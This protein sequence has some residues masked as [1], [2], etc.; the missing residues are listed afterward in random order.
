M[1]TFIK[2]IIWLFLVLA[3]TAANAQ[4]SQKAAELEIEAYQYFLENNYQKASDIYLKAIQ[5]ELK[6]DNPGSIFIARCYQSLAEVKQEEGKY[7]EAIGYLFQAMDLMKTEA[8]TVLVDEFILQLASYYNA[9]EEN[10]LM[11]ETDPDSLQKTWVVFRIDSVLRISNDT[12]WVCINGG[13]N[14]NITEGSTGSAFSV[15]SGD[16]PDRG[17][18]ILGNGRLLETGLNHS[19][20]YVVLNNTEDADYQVRIGDMLEFPCMLPA[21]DETSVFTNLAKL[22]ILFNN[23]ENTPIFE[24]IE[25]LYNT[26]L[27]LEQ[28]IIRLMV[29]D[30]HKT[31]E[32][33]QEYVDDNPSWTAPMEGGKYDGMS[34]MYGL[35][36]TTVSD[37]E[38]F[39]NFVISYPGKY[40][41]KRWKIN[42]TYATWLINATPL[43]EFDERM[44]QKILKL[45]GNA[46]DEYI[47]ENDFYIQDS[48]LEKFNTFFN[49]ALNEHDYERAEKMVD[50]LIRITEIIENDVYK[51]IFLT[52]KGTIRINQGKWLESL[53]SFDDAIGI[54]PDNLNA[55]FFRGYAYGELEDYY[56]AVQDYKKITEINP[57]ISVGHGNMGWYMLL[58]GRIFGA[59]DA[60]RKAY[61][62]DSSAMSNAVNLGHAHLLLGDTASARPYYDRTLELL[63]TT[64][65]F[66][67]GPLADFDI[68][69]ENGWQT[70]LVSQAKNYVLERFNEDYKYYVLADS[71]S[72]VAI[73]NK[74]DA[75]YELAAE[76]MLKA[77]EYEKQSKNPRPY[78]LYWETSWIGY[79][80]QQME[81]YE[82]TEEYYKLCLHYAHDVMKSDDK[83]ANAYDLL[84]WLY[85]DWGK[86]SEAYA[87]T[88]KSEAYARKVEESGKSRRIYLL[89][90][91]N[92]NFEELSY[93]YADEDAQILAGL[94]GENPSQYYDSVSTEVITNE[95][96][97]LN[98]LEQAFKNVI[99]DSR[100][101][102]V[103]VFY[104]GGTGSL[105]T[106][107]F[108]LNIP[109]HDTTE[110]T[111][112]LKVN[113]IKTWL[114]SVQARNQFLMLDIF[115][116]TFIDEFV[117]NYAISRGAFSGSN[118]NLGILSLAGHRI[119]DDSLKHGA[120]THSVLDII[121]K[122]SAMPQAKDKN[123]SIK[124]INAHLF[125]EQK[126]NG[127]V[128]SWNT[129]FTGEDFVLIHYDSISREDRLRPNGP[130]RSRGVGTLAMDYEN[131]TT[132]SGEPTR[133]ALLF[134]TNEYDEWSDL[135]NPMYDANA[136][137]KTLEEDYGFEVELL[138][139]NT[140]MDV[141]M[142]IREY[143]K[144]QY[145]PN[146]HLFIFFAGHGSFD[147][148]SGEGY[149]VC[150]DSKK[151]DEIRASYIPYSYLRENVNNIKG[152]RHI[153]IALDV[154]FGGTFDKQVSK[155]A[156]GDN[157]YD[158]ISKDAFINRAMQ[159]KSRLFITS[160]S[161]EYVSDGD[162]GKHS[163]F[164]YNLLD[165][166]RS[167]SMTN[168]YVT[169]NMLV[170]AVERLQTTPRYGDFGDNEPGSEFI[171]DVQTVIPQKAFKVKDLK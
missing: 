7:N 131:E 41:A 136:L 34:M 29:D 92:N 6:E 83:T 102:D 169:F 26:D 22:N 119:E 16:E 75:E 112:A 36:Q 68:F 64:S 42:E 67:T 90:V 121:K 51:A 162:P 105:D 2:P 117:G 79:M 144:K 15:Y 5:E 146:D 19:Y 1:K 71:I 134:A 138:T 77:Y 114:S 32:F 148:I 25:M 152:C 23:M 66:E 69:L 20:A 39:L 128:L 135:V 59:L 70:E 155:F 56:K 104:L 110:K 31:W 103:F 82:K 118:L 165:V 108:S 116:P 120:F 101:D 160:G 10:N 156:R 159:F 133:Y 3:I 123:L 141:L 94:L 49:E 38:A 145:H 27:Q 55:Y 45:E 4:V 62:L 52:G 30:I 84:A 58:G 98:K 61:E 50:K 60:C 140:R 13:S 150:R 164:A 142:K 37:V 124:D 149:I 85:G 87:Y 65:E 129:Y 139:D 54:D 43:G 57:E 122:E 107:Q 171:F 91:G 127:N 48:T 97:S 46:F 8:D 137:A 170:Q 24:Q 11:L 113:T 63:N 130:D 88:E 28:D 93:K 147:D 153:L 80:Y 44:Y 168:G 106:N 18:I 74:D 47:V 40:M 154:C 21:K 53:K 17:N 14:E 72:D 9:I 126:G 143:Q 100:P 33:L 166:L 157:T 115:A 163:P 132:Y 96:L 95:E 73:A 76:N 125:T 78:W 99:L 111:V 35:K 161:K 81:D 86:K 167:Q 12:M 158:Q 151:D 89:A 109:M